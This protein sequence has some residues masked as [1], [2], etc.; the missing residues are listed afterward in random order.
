LFEL[1]DGLHVHAQGLER[2]QD[3]AAAAARQRRQRQQY[4]VDIAV[5]D[6]HRQLLGGEYLDAV[7]RTSM[8]A[9]VVVDKHQ[10]IKRPRGR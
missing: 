7:D 8:Q 3:L 5:L 9:A 2:A 1:R 10:R 6:Q 4:A